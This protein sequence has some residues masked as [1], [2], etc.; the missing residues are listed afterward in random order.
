MA[1]TLQFKFDPNQEH[2]TRAI[3]STLAL[4]DGLPAFNSVSW[5]GDEIVPNMDLFESLDEEWLNSNL[6]KVQDENRILT[7]ESFVTYDDGLMIEGLG[8]DSWRFPQFTVEM[9][10][11]T[12]K[13]Y[14]YLRT[15]YELRKNYGFKK[16]LIVVPS[17]AIYEGVKSSFD[18]MKSHFASLYGNE[19]T[20][21]TAYS[22]QQL[23]KLRNFATSSFTEILL[24]TVD[25]FNKKT[26]NIFKPTEKLPGELLP[27]QYIQNTRPILILDE[28]QNYTSSTSKEALRTLKPIFSLNYSAT[29]LE[30]HNLIY[31]LTPI[32]AFRQ[33][34]VKKIEVLGV[35]EQWSFGDQQLRLT[36]ESISRAS[37]GLAAEMR[38]FVNRGGELLEQKLSLKKNDDLF[39]KTRNEKY[40]GIVVESI[41][42]SIGLVT[43]EN[44]PDLYLN[45]AGA[46]SHSKEE[47]FRVQIENTIK[48][49]FEKQVEIRERGIKVLS[50][51]FIDRVANYVS[52]DGIIKKI[53]DESFER[54]KK[55]Q[56][57]F[58]KFFA[59]DVREGYFAKKQTKNQPEEYVDTT[60]EESKKTAADKELEKAA[61]HLI[62]KSKERL[63][64]F[65]EKVS[66]IFAHS[67]LKEGWDNPNVFQT[68]TLK[69]TT[70]EMRKR[71]EI[72]RGMRLAV[73]QNG[74]RINGDDVNILTVIANESYDSYVSTLQSEYVET[75]DAAPPTPSNAVKKHA[76]RNDKLF[77]S[78]EFKKFWIHLCQ[79]TD[80][81]INVATE[82][83]IS[84][85]I[86]K[87]NAIQF[88]EPQIV[89]THGKFVLTQ[90]SVQLI[91]IKAKLAKI[92][93]E[94][95]DTDGNTTTNEKWF[96]SLNDLARILN[97]QR[98][99]GY[100]IVDI[101]S[102]GERSRVVF[103]DKGELL[104]G[105]KVTESSEK[106]Q[107]INPTNVHESQITF[108]IFNLIDRAAKETNLTRPTILKIFKG[109][110]ERAKC[111]IF[112]NPE[113]FANVFISTIKGLLASHI[114]ERIEY[115][116][117]PN[118]M[119]DFLVE[120]L[121]PETAKF[122]QKELISGSRASLYDQVQIDSDIE[123][124]FIEKRLKD[125]EKVICY[126]KFPYR[127]KINIPKIIG[128]YNPD[129]GIIRWDEDKNLKLELVR[130]TKGNI[131]PNLLQYKNEKRKIDC[132]KKHFKVVKI[133]YRQM[134]D[135]IP[136]YWE[137]GN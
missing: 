136:N 112:K 38:A 107:K 79:K 31:R 75:G 93:V 101:I 131:D 37:Y 14:V 97:D 92:R 130:E 55:D 17:I 103:G 78:E 28:C 72:G 3:E 122:P 128:N 58:E 80:Y 45:E 34:L 69:Q 85:C 83:L 102:D 89:L 24:I 25:S 10:T 44:H 109:M 56:P 124:N 63:L 82:D 50:L 132:A 22:G 95:S 32:D 99:K 27:Y 73:D 36:L 91:E 23:S 120:E 105:Q 114:A 115:V 53:F 15:I 113:G 5:L 20:H 35:T 108:P 16:F 86:N 87:L 76:K 51:F 116:L 29:P 119:E 12:G 118:E 66:F 61:Y 123:K 88:P 71:Q 84:A 7:T 46:I 2:Q 57:F 41:D 49:H 21:L 100:K 129:W 8:I 1:K 26:N 11:G 127:F 13:T 137:P 133:D 77:N 104:V 110:S 43:F 68:C 19:P 59:N 33:S 42:A 47:I 125:D 4:F 70:S 67:A 65:D 98:L 134:T 54:L 62:M 74:E 94:S 106:G 111:S 48:Y 40:K 9:E 18:T 90:I 30:K 126:F 64:S 117:R 6:K 52:N 96:S 135:Q 60:F 121:F 81:K 39:E